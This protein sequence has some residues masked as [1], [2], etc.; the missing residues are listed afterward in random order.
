MVTFALLKRKLMNASKPRLIAFYLPQF[1]PIPENDKWWGAGFTEW[2][3]VRKARPLFPGHYQPKVPTELG[4][5]DLRSVDVRIKQAQLAQS[6]GIEGFCFWHYWFGGRRLL[7]QVFSEIVSSG[8]PDFPFCLCWANHSWYKKTWSLS[9]SR[10]LLVKQVYNGEADY[11]AHFYAMLP[12]FRDKRYLKVD[13]KLMFGIFDPVSMPDIDIFR[14][15]WNELARKN[16]LNGFYF[17]ACSSPKCTSILIEKGYDA[18]VEDYLYAG[19][20]RHTTFWQLLNKIRTNVFKRPYVESYDE[21]VKLALDNYN[22]AVNVH[23]SIYPNFDHSPRSGTRGRILH[24]SNPDKWGGFCDKIF[25]KSSV[26]DHEHNIIFI[27]AWNEWGEGNYLEPDR[28]FGRGYLDKTLQALV[29]FDCKT[30]TGF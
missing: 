6:A 18:V 11:S 15:V 17:F 24:G 16:G 27:K 22:P 4:Y 14:S 23:Q 21:Y 3:N 19:I 25:E 8:I 1:Y 26:R 12:A 5:Y 28:K 9:N 7:E 29:N 20:D 2:T 13:G 10:K 30:S